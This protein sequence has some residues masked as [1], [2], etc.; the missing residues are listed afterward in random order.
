M[1]NWTEERLNDELGEKLTAVGA[2]TAPTLGGSLDLNSNAFVATLTAGEALVRDDLCYFATN[3]KLYKTDADNDKTCKG[4]LMIATETIAADAAGVFCVQGF[5]ETTG[6]A[7]G[8]IIYVS[9][10]S[11]TW[12]NYAPYGSGDVVRIIGYGITN[13][14]MFFHPDRTYAEMT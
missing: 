4:L 5:F 1:Y 12:Q 13:T 14:Q 10:E 7:P 6:F 11:G 3:G 8:D 9:T 2:D